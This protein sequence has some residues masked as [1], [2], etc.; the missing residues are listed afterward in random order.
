MSAT[1]SANAHAAIVSA[2]NI[3][4]ETEYNDER[5][6]AVFMVDAPATGN[7]YMR[8]WLN[9]TSSDNI[10]FQAHQV[11]INDEVV[12]E[13]IPTASGWQS[14][15]ISE[16]EKVM[17]YQGENEIRITGDAIAAPMID[18]VR[19]SDDANQA[20][21]ASSTSLTQTEAAQPLNNNSLTTSVTPPITDDYTCVTTYYSFSK[22]FRL[23]PGQLITIT[24]TGEAAHGIDFFLYANTDT[25]NTEAAINDLNWYNGSAAY[26]ST[27]TDHRA[28]INT[29][30]PVLGIY[31]MML[32][33]GVSRVPQNI[34]DLEIC[35]KDSVDDAE[36]TI[37]TYTDCQASMTR[38]DEVIPADGKEYR[39]T[40]I[41]KLL[42]LNQLPSIDI[43]VEGDASEP[44][45]VVRHMQTASNGVTHT[46][47]IGTIDAVYQI[48]AT[49][50]HASVSSSLAVS[51]PCYINIEE[52]PDEEST[53]LISEAPAR[54]NNSTGVDVI[55]ESEVR[56][57]VDGNNIIVIQNDTNSLV[58]V[59][60]LSGTLIYSGTNHVIPVA[61][62]GIYI[63]KV[64]EETFK[65]AK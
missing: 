47:Y 18:S 7:Y 64:G 52:T 58:E 4:Q 30:I 36:P 14:I 50:I 33:S 2:N 40:A 43:C 34:S 19:I 54:E 5:C 35:V 23:K 15:G 48:P 51:S 41:N 62:R 38:L 53:L 31:K 17:L 55:T 25:I 61:E 49:G 11:I 63:V 46:Y 24:T 29:K 59:Y 56:V 6:D 12:G 60:N 42:E 8:F 44:S 26:S 3:R 28:V 27:S 1:W 21:I 57:F 13:I 39:V 22:K 45:R 37:Y 10:S 16:V 20:E 65:V 9:P 32:R